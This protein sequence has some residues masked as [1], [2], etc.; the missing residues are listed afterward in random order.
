MHSLHSPTRSGGIGAGTATAGAGDGTT[1]G[2]L[3]DLDGVATDGTSV[4]VGVAS[5]SAGADLAG[6]SLGITTDG[7]AQAGALPASQAV[8]SVDGE[9]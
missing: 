4:L 9:A 5:A 6:T 2:P 7:T 8:A 3:T 1:D